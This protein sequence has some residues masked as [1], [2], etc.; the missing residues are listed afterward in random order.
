MS[1]TASERAKRAF[2]NRGLGLLERV[3]QYM[4][5]AESGCIEWTGTLTGSGYAQI[6]VGR[7]NAI[8][9]RLL[10]AER[11]GDIQPGLIV[12]HKC[13]NRT[14]CNVEHLFLGSPKDNTMDMVA[15]RRHVFGVSAANAKLTDAD[16]SA[17][18]LEQGSDTKVAA[19]WGVARSLI[20]AIRKG[21]AWA[22]V[23]R[24]AAEADNHERRA[25]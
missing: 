7:K 22:H 25:A 6:R 12:C 8:V 17:I 16:V 11:H 24:P 13:D 21:K 18:L 3:R 2:S 9:T 4:R 15:K 19:K 20:Y 5:P 14:C 23:P 10:W 1:G